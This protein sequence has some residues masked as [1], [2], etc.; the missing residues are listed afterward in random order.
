MGGTKSLVIREARCGAHSTRVSSTM[1]CFWGGWLRVAGH[2]LAL[3][4]ESSLERLQMGISVVVGGAGLG[5]AEQPRAGKEGRG[6]GGMGDPRFAGPAAA[7]GHPAP[8]AHICTAPGTRLTSLQCQDGHRETR[9]DDA[10]LRPPPQSRTEEDAG[11]GHGGAASA[12][13]H[14]GGPRRAPRVGAQP[15]SPVL[16]MPVSCHG[17]SQLCGGEH[18]PS[19]L[20]LRTPGPWDPS[21]PRGRGRGGLRA[22]GR[23]CSPLLDAP[24]LTHR[25]P[26]GPAA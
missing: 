24:L 2:Q 17:A 8:R 18:L 12:H 4:R 11:R 3:S 5:V 16:V 9:P 6:E 19:R 13:A 26:G 22:P 14:A 21:T 15:R 23:V 7:P 10:R 1:V 20:V 25:S